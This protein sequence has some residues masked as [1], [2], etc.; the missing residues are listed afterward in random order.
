MSGTCKARQVDSVT[1]AR[2]DVPRTPVIPGQLWRWDFSVG[3]GSWFGQR[4]TDEARFEPSFDGTAVILRDDT[5][6]IVVVDDPGPYEQPDYLSSVY[7]PASTSPGM[8]AKR[9]HV[10]LL[11]HALVWIEDGWLQHCELLCNPNG[12]E[13]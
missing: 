1:A 13:A 10:A 9:W 4:V 5:F 8:V 2:C 3:D 7:D 11:N 12:D 6:V